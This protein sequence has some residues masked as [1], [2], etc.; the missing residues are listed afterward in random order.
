MNKY[1][2]TTLIFC[3]VWFIAALLNGLLSGISIAVLDSDSGNEAMGNL[4][5]SVF[6]SFVFSAP[7]AVFVW[8]VTL[9]A[10]LADKKGQE[11]F[12]LVLR[13]VLICSS[14]V[15]LLFFHTLGTEFKNSRWLA[16]IAIVIS[17]M[18][19]VLLFRKPIK[20]NA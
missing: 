10:Q 20:A 2:K 12:L 8:F 7:L 11:L 5:M 6:F 18:S 13:T 17:A 3:G 9:L 19:A 4:A 1:I 14:L 16:G 15:A